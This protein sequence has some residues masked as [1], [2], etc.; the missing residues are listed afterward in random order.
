[1]ELQQVDRNNFKETVSKPGIVLID[2]WAE[3]CGGCKD[4]DPVF[5]SV[6]QR[7]PDHTFARL[8]T[9]AEEELVDELG[10]KHIPSLM[11]FRDGILLY[12]QPGNFDENAL[13]DI[14]N[15]AES[16][17]MGLVRAEIAAARDEDG[18]THVA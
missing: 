8:D 10:I 11:L 3:W 16:L 15:Q 7:H 18:N 17:D 4:F 12:K 5:D 1:M 6:A 9:Q 13:E 2:C 14:V